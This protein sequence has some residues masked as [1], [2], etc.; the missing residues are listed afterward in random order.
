MQDYSGYGEPPFGGYG[1]TAPLPPMPPRPPRRRIGL[2]SYLAVALA[3]GALGAGTVVALYHPAANSSAAPSP[4]SRAVAPTPLPS[5]AVPAPGSGGSAAAGGV[6]GVLNRVQPGVVIINTALQYNSEQAAGTG[7]AINSDG[8]VL[9]NNHVIENATK[10]TATLVS[11]GQTYQAKVVGYDV[12]GDIALI[13]LQNAAGLHP[14]PIGDSGTVKTGATVVAMGNANG[15]SA[16]TPAVGRV[17]ALNQTIT[18]SDQGGAVSSETL[19]GMIE[20]DA[21][22]VAGDS[23]GPLANTAGQVIG[24][25]T[26]GNSVSLPQQQSVAGFAIPINTALSVAHQIAAGKA[27]ST[28]TIGYP[29]F[30]GIY[31]GKGSDSNPQDQ[32]AQQE[33]GNGFGGGFGGGGFGGGGFGGGN[34]SGGNGSQSCYT[35]GAGLSA[36][37][38]IAP[39]SSGT[40]VIGTICNSPAAAAGLTAGSVI[41]GVNGQ[42]VGAPESLTA[43][44][45]RFR[46]G[47]TLSVTWVTPSGQRQTG[48]LTLTAGPPL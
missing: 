33:N 44:V 34:G 2:L 19:H 28:I 40:L 20:T 21:D 9:T 31:I 14:V 32:A 39:V 4:G 7:M 1:S 35:S 6:Q 42:A 18:A 24:M 45:S 27:S 47:D 43:I 13:Q 11:T 29:P 30:L 26:A 22:V 38:A 8:L 3:A 48:N 36:P 15:Q 12:T 5:N 17:T 46:P 37:S 16:I 23:G 41:T 10:I 25:D